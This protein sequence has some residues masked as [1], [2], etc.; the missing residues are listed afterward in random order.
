MYDLILI[1]EYVKGDTYA[2]NKL[3]SKHRDHL[4][5][6]I[7]KNNKGMI[8]QSEDILQDS[9]IAIE[10][11]IRKGQF[12]GRN[13]ATV[14]GWMATICRYQTLQ[15]FRKQKRNPSNP[16]FEDF[17]NVYEELPNTETDKLNYTKDIP[18]SEKVFE[19]I[20]LLPNKDQ[21]FAISERLKGKTCLDIAK[22]SSVPLSTAKA[23]I[24]HA[25]KKLNVIYLESLKPH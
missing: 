9:I 5:E 14:I 15:H 21:A 7:C 10:K 13:G 20:L 8:E 2:F 17:T 12:D 22:L 25:S 1:E 24:R 19:L 3:I 16:T 11:N 4:L 6:T 18:I 23:R